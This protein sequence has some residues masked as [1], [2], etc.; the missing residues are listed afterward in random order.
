MRYTRDQELNKDVGEKVAAPFRKLFHEIGNN[1]ITGLAN[2]KNVARLLVIRILLM[3]SSG[4]SGIELRRIRGDT[5]GMMGGRERRVQAS[6]YSPEA[7]FA[8][9]FY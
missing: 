5:V 2:T 4:L 7:S 9:E 6:V 3:I 1:V 8:H